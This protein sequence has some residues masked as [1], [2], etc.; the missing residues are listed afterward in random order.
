MNMYQRYK[1]FKE[2]DALLQEKKE[3]FAKEAKRREQAEKRKAK[4]A[5]KKKAKEE[6]KPKEGDEP[7]DDNWISLQTVQAVVAG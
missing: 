2:A 6:A 1:K 5:K 7:V 4:T 3:Q